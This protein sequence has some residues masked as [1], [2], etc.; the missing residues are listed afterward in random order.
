MS[1][2]IDPREAIKRRQ[3]QQHDEIIAGGPA[4]EVESNETKRESK[5]EQFNGTVSLNSDIEQ[6]GENGKEPATQGGKTVQFY[7]TETG[8]NQA[9]DSDKV[10]AVQPDKTP[11]RNF[12]AESFN[13]DTS[14]GRKRVEDTHKRDTFLIEKELLHKLNLIAKQQPKGYKKK[15]INDFLRMYLREIEKNYPGMLDEE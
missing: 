12:I 3:K 2:K 14:H 6:T 8:N 15:L 1:K 7:G 13:V 11:L 10:N 5:T 9:G 4:A